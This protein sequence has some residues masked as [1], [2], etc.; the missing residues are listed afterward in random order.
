M[1]DKIREIITEYNSAINT[2]VGSVLYFF[3]VAPAAA[4]YTYITGLVTTFSQQMAINTAT[5]KTALISNFGLDK[6]SGVTAK[7]GL[8]LQLSSKQTFYN[9]PEGTLFEYVDGN[10]VVSTTDILVSATTTATIPVE[11]STQTSTIYSVGDIF[12]CTI[13]G[14]LVEACYVSTQIAGGT[15]A[16]TD[17]GFLTRMREYLN[18]SASTPIGLALRITSNYTIIDCLVNR[19]TM[20]IRQGLNRLSGVPI[21]VY[22]KG[23]IT[24]KEVT[25]Y[26]RTDGLFRLNDMVFEVVSS[27]S[28]L[29][30]PLKYHELTSFEY[31][32]YSAVP[33]SVT[34][35]YLTVDISSIQTY[36][37][38]SS[39]IPIGLDILIRHATPVYISGTIYTTNDIS[40]QLNTMEQYVTHHKIIQFE[41]TTMLA[42]A[43]ITQY[44]LPLNLVYTPITAIYPA[45]YPKDLL[46]SRRI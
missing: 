34:I 45:Y 43:G 18:N 23:L 38:T 2:R 21:D 17:D 5:D 30:T 24:E 10:T 44:D 29:T 28:P 13:Y 41:P 15:E 11:T 42:S 26:K 14:T 31:N 40:T 9:F 20:G 33:N 36:V 1:I 27:S 3:L 22:I 6:Y 12:S 35:K 25:L 16:E 19:G 7:G 46:L 4:V 37:D 32:T 39:E 8:T